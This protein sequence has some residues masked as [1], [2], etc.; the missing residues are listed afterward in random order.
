MIDRSEGTNH[1]AG[2]DQ[3]YLPTDYLFIHAEYHFK[4]FVLRLGV[5]VQ[6][7]SNHDEIVLSDLY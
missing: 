6:A 5:E 4:F 1:R 3:N 2:L 7:K